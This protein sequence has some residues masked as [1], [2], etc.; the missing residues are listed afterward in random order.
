MS[1]V[2]IRLRCSEMSTPSWR[3]ASTEC[4]VG[5]WPSTAPSPAE[6][7]RNSPRPAAPRRPP[8]QRLRHRAATDVAGAHEQNGFH[9]AQRFKVNS[10]SPIVNPK[11]GA[12]LTDNGETLD[13]VHRARQDRIADHPHLRPG[14]IRRQRIL[15]TFTAVIWLWGGIGTPF[16]P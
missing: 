3:I 16:S 5:G 2:S 13:Q 9:A 14:A 11:S 15:I 7:A 6:N 8:E 4:T 1:A 12:R 10:E